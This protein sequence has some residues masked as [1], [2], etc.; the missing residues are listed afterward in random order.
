MSVGSALLAVLVVAAITYGMR[1]G[2]ILAIAGRDLPAIVDRMLRHVGPAVLTALA[3]NLAVDP[4]TGRPLT[5]A[6]IGMSVAA[7]VGGWRRNL[8]LATL[9]GMSAIWFLGWVG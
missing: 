8:L 7:V 1:A 6:V 2:M 5:G 3:V 4:R 9:G